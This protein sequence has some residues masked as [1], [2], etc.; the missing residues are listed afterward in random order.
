M[1]KRRDSMPDLPVDRAL[2]WGDID[3]TGQ[4]AF[5]ND[6]REAG[7]MR[8]NHEGVLEK[9]R[10]APDN[11]QS[12]KRVARLQNVGPYL[13]DRPMTLRGA[14]SRR[15][16]HFENGMRRSS[17]EGVDSGAG[18]YFGHHESLAGSGEEHGYSGDTAIRAGTI[19]SPLNSPTN[20]RAALGALAAKSR[21]AEYSDSDLRRGG[22]K[23]NISRAQGMLDEQLTFS[24]HGGSKPEGHVGGPKIHSYMSATVDAVPGTAEHDEY[25]QR[26]SHVSQVLN[27]QQISGQQYLDVTGKRDSTEGIL[28]PTRNT[29]EDSWMNA[30]STG[31]RIEGTIPGT[32][33]NVAKAVADDD[34]VI[35]RPKG[36]AYPGEPR[37]GRMD[38]LHAWNN[39]ATV[40]AA[41]TMGRR[42]GLVNDQGQSMVPS[43]LMQE[44]AWTEARRV[45][46]KDPEYEAPKEPKSKL[47][48]DG[49]IPGQRSWNI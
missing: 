37:V 6:Q 1:A 33:Q 35:K 22:T 9:A 40:R 36:D 42:T 7:M 5:E 38:V 13:K 18:W 29:A 41:A 44:V 4:K 34:S 49:Q 25:M 43:V 27:G 20:E 8:S 2:Q 47:D 11:P 12:Q 24:P 21:G 31:Q 23:R 45:A 14:S 3:R 16:D 19:M 46:N 30:I 15:V 39:E 17:E 10:S 48:K 26:A 28:S 32:K